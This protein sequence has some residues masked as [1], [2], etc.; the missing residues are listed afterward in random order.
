[1][2]R[3]LLEIITGGIAVRPED[4]EA[5]EK[6]TYLH[7]CLKHRSGDDNDFK[8]AMGSTITFLLE[9][10]FITLGKDEV[11]SPSVFQDGDGGPPS[12]GSFL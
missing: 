4:V 7:T 5:Y 3:A 6:C 2:K 10:E 11:R 1:M 9:N 12:K 8:E